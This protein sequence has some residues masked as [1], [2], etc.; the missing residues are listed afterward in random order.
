M[1]TLYKEHTV[2]AGTFVSISFGEYFVQGANPTPDSWFDWTTA[3]PFGFEVLI[4]YTF[5]APATLG[6][7]DYY[8]ADLLSP[9]GSYYIRINVVVGDYSLIN[10]CCGDRNLAW[11]NIQGGWQNYI[12][13]G[14]KTFQVEVNGSKQFK[15]NEYI[16]KHSQIEG[17]FNGE[18]ITS[19]D[20]PK[21]HVDALDNLKYA[22][23]VFMYNEETEAWDIPLLVD[24][25][26]FTKYQS[27]DKF[28]EVRLKFIYATEILVQTQ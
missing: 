19:G 2:S 10:N 18:V 28:Y 27:R 20:I 22:I 16:S 25:G 6:T 24:V 11:L 9:A 14:I 13:T 1:A 5:T 15:T 7:Y 17:V 21:A 26:S 8:F 3:S 4:G 12:F 23:Q